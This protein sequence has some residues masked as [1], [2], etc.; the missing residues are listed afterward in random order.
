MS[1]VKY[2]TRDNKEIYPIRYDV[3]AFC[4]FEEISGGKSLINGTDN[5]DMRCIRALVFVG[6]ACGHEFNGKEFKLRPYDI[7]KWDDL[8][9]TVFPQCAAVLKEMGPTK[10]EKKTSEASG[11]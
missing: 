8:I 10:E 9:S 11:E 4:Q 7:G 3:N 5:F 6:L 2:I 1:A